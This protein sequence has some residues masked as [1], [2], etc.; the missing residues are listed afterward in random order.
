MK[1]ERIAKFQG[2]NLFIKN[3]SD[4]VDDERLRTEFAPFGSITS[5][6][7]RILCVSA[8]SFCCLHEDK[9]PAAGKL[10][11]VCRLVSS[12]PAT[13]SRQGLSV[14]RRMQ[15]M[16]DAGGKSRGFGFVC[17]TTNEEATRA[18]T[19]ANSKMVCGKPIFVALAQ[20]KEVPPWFAS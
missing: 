15:V 6:T 14:L 1:K 13:L 7:V 12:L 16:R 19:E 4:E 5:A 20:Q 17:F 11:A 10:Q 18:I 3:L 2:L 8:G 9:P